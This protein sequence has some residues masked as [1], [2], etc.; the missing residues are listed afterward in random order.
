MANDLDNLEAEAA[1]VAGQISTA[2]RLRGDAE[3]ILSSE[4]VADGER[5]DAEYA[6]AENTELICQHQVTLE[7]LTEEWA[8]Q[9]AELHTWGL[10]LRELGIDPDRVPRDT[11]TA[12]AR[13]AREAWDTEPAAADQVARLTRLWRRR[14]M[15]PQLTGVGLTRR[16]VDDALAALL[17]ADGAENP[18]PSPDRPVIVYTPRAPLDTSGHLLDAPALRPVTVDAEILTDSDALTSVEDLQAA[19]R[20]VTA[21]VHSGRR[22]TSPQ[23]Q[24]QLQVILA[25]ASAAPLQIPAPMM[26]RLEVICAALRAGHRLALRT[27]PELA[28]DVWVLVS[29]DS[30]TEYRALLADDRLRGPAPTAPDVGEPVASTPAATRNPPAP[31]QV[32]VP[33]LTEDLL[34]RVCGDTDIAAAAQQAVDNQAFY[35][36]ALLDAQSMILGRLAD[37]IDPDNDA[38]TRRRARELLEDRAALTGL[39]RRAVEQVWN[40]VHDT[41]ATQAR[42]AQV[43]AHVLEFGGTEPEDLQA[44]LNALDEDLPPTERQQV[45]QQAFDAVNAVTVIDFYTFGFDAVTDEQLTPPDPDDDGRVAVAVA[46]YAEAGTAAFIRAK[47]LEGWWAG[48]SAHTAA[49]WADIRADLTAD[50]ELHTLLT[51]PDTPQTRAAAAARLDVLL[52]THARRSPLHAAAVRAAEYTQS[53]NLLGDPPPFREPAVGSGDTATGTDLHPGRDPEIAVRDALVTT[54][55]TDPGIRAGQASTASP[56][57]TRPS[58]AVP[59]AEHAEVAASATACVDCGEDTAALAEIY[60]VLPAVWAATGLGPD[61]GSLCVGCLEQRL[62][63][64]LDATDFTD[65]PTNLAHTPRSARLQQRID[66]IPVDEHT[67]YLPDPDDLDL[68]AG[69]EVDDLDFDAGDEVDGDGDLIRGDD[70]ATEADDQE[71]VAVAPRP[72]PAVIDV[73]LPEPALPVDIHA[74]TQAIPAQTPS[75]VAG[76][77]W[78]NIV[79]ELAQDPALQA[80]LRHRLLPP[81]LAVQQPELRLLL[82]RMLTDVSHLSPHHAAAVDARRDA[83]VAGLADQERRSPRPQPGDLIA[84]EVATR[85]VRALLAAEA[86]YPELTVGTFRHWATD[87]LLADPLMAACAREPASVPAAALTREMAELLIG[88]AVQMRAALGIDA[89]DPSTAEWI[90]HE[91]CLLLAPTLSSSETPW[92]YQDSAWTLDPGEGADSSDRIRVHGDRDRGWWVSPDGGLTRLS[93]G[94]DHRAAMHAGQQRADRGEGADE[95]TSAAYERVESTRR[96]LIEFADSTLSA[97]PRIRAAA[98]APQLWTGYPD[99]ALPH[100]VAEGPWTVDAVADVLTALLTD[101]PELFWRAHELGLDVHHIVHFESAVPQLRRQHSS[102]LASGEPGLQILA[103]DTVIVEDTQG[104]QLRLDNPAT[105]ADSAGAWEHRDS[106]GN[107]L[108]R[109]HRFSAAWQRARD[110]L[111]GNPIP[112]PVSGTGFGEIPTAVPETA[113]QVGTQIKRLGAWAGTQGW[114]PTSHYI[115]GE[116]SETSYTLAMHAATETVGDWE[117]LLRWQFDH[118]NGYTYQ[119]HGSTGIWRRPDGTRLEFTPQLAVLG[120]LILAHPAAVDPGPT[121][122]PQTDDDAVAVEIPRAQPDPPLAPADAEVAPS[123]EDILAEVATDPRVHAEIIN[124]QLP[125]L[126][127]AARKPLQRVVDE[128]LSE[129][130]GR[131]P[132]SEAAV[133]AARGTE[134]APHLQIRDIAEQVAQRAGQQLLAHW[135]PPLTGSELTA[136]DQWAHEQMLADPMIAARAGAA[137]RRETEIVT[138]A[139]ARNLIDRTPAQ[140][141]ELDLDVT[142]EATR[143]WLMLHVVLDLRPSLPAVETSWHFTD[144]GY[145]PDKGTGTLINRLWQVNVG[146]KALW[147]EWANHLAAQVAALEHHRRGAEATLEARRAY[148]E[149]KQLRDD[150]GGFVRGILLADPRIHAVAGAR[151]LWRYGVDG[152]ERFAL[153]RAAAKDVLAALVREEHE[154]F[155]RAHH[156]GVSVDH[157]VRREVILTLLGRLRRKPDASAPPLVTQSGLPITITGASN[158]TVADNTRDPIALVCKISPGAAPWVYQVSAEEPPLIWALDLEDAIRVADA[159]HTGRLDRAEATAIAAAARTAAARAAESRPD[160]VP[161]PDSV[162]VNW[163]A[164][165]VQPL[166]RFAADHGCTVQA[167]QWYLDPDDGSEQGYDLHLTKATTDGHHLDILLRWAPITTWAAEFDL[168]NSHIIHTYP[169]GRVE[170][171]QPQRPLVKTLIASIADTQADAAHPIATSPDTAVEPIPQASIPP[172]QAQAPAPRAPQQEPAAAPQ[173]VAAAETAGFALTAPDARRPRPDHYELDFEA[174]TDRGPVRGHLEW[175]FFGSNFRLRQSACS[176]DVNGVESTPT[177]G[178]ILNLLRRVTVIA[179]PPDSLPASAEASAGVVVVEEKLPR[180]PTVVSRLNQTAIDLDWDGEIVRDGA[181]RFELRLTPK[182]GEPLQFRMFWLMS[183]VTG[184]YNFDRWRS[185]ISH[186]GTID[187]GTIPSPKFMQDKLDQL[188]LNSTQP[189]LFAADGSIAAHLV[190]ALTEATAPSAPVE[191]TAGVEGPRPDAAPSP[192]SDSAPAPAASRAAEAVAGEPG[193]EV[194]TSHRHETVWSHIVEPLPAVIPAALAEA[195]PLADLARSNDYQV[196]SGFRLAPKDPAEV[197]DTPRDPL[198][199]LRIHGHRGISVDPLIACWRQHDGQW[200]FDEA[201]STAPRTPANLATF[202]TLV[203]KKPTATPPGAGPVLDAVVAHVLATVERPHGAHSYRACLEQLD[204]QVSTQISRVL[205]QIVDT[206]DDPDHAAQWRMAA[207]AM[208]NNPL[209]RQQ[210]TRA[211]IARI[212]IGADLTHTEQAAIRNAVDDHAYLYYQLHRSAE[213]AVRYTWEAHLGEHAKGDRRRVITAAIEVEVTDRSDEVLDCGPKVAELRAKTRGEFVDGLLTRA[214]SALQAGEGHTARRMLTAAAKTSPAVPTIADLRQIADDHFPPA[215]ERDDREIPVPDNAA[216]IVS[217]T[218]ADDGWTQIRAREEGH[219]FV[220]TLRRQSR[221]GRRYHLRLVWTDSDDGPQ[222]DPDASRASVI[223]DRKAEPFPKR[224]TRHYAARI[225]ALAGDQTMPPLPSQH[226]IAPELTIEQRILLYGLDPWAVSE[227]LADPHHGVP[228]LFDRDETAVLNSQAC[229]LHPDLRDTAPIYEIADDT[230]A[231]AWPGGPSRTVTLTRATLTELAGAVSDT[232]R[233]RLANHSSHSARHRVLRELLDLDTLTSQASGTEPGEDPVAA[234][235][236]PTLRSDP[237]GEVA[238]AYLP[239]LEG[240]H[241]R[242][243]AASGRLDLYAVFTHAF[244]D[245]L[246]PSFLRVLAQSSEFDTAAQGL[247]DS[248]VEGSADEATVDAF[249]ARVAELGWRRWRPGISNDD[250]RA[251]GELDERGWPRPYRLEPGRERVSSVLFDRRSSSPIEINLHVNDADYRV[252]GHPGGG[253]QILAPAGSTRPPRVIATL[254]SEQANQILGIIRADVAPEISTETGHLDE[255]GMAATRSA[256]PEGSG[257]DVVA[258]EQRWPIPKLVRLSK[259]KLTNGLLEAVRVVTDEP[260]KEALIE[261]ASVLSNTS[262]ARKNGG[263]EAVARRDAE[264]GPEQ[265]YYAAMADLADELDRRGYGAITIAMHQ[266]STRPISVYLR[267][268]AAAYMQ[269]RAELENTSATASPAQALPAPPIAGPAPRTVLGTAP[270]TAATD[271]DVQAIRDAVVGWVQPQLENQYSDLLYFS[272]NYEPDVDRGATLKSRPFAAGLVAGIVDTLPTANPE[273]ASAVAA[274]GLDA[275]E[276][277]TDLVGA[278]LLEL[279]T[280]YNDGEQLV[281]NSLFV[282][283]PATGRV[284]LVYEPGPHPVFSEYGQPDSPI[285]S[286]SLT[287]AIG[288]ARAF[289]AHRDTSIPAQR[290]RIPQLPATGQDRVADREAFAQALLAAALSGTTGYDRWACVV[291]AEMLQNPQWADSSS[292]VVARGLDLAYRTPADLAARWWP[293]LAQSHFTAVRELADELDRLGYHDFGVAGGGDSIPETLG[294]ALRQYAELCIDV[295]TDLATS[296]D[297]DTA[298]DVPGPAVPAVDADRGNESAQ[299]APTVDERGASATGTASADAD[300]WRIPAH[301]AGATGKVKKSLSQ[302]LRRAANR[303][304]TSADDGAALIMAADSLIDTGWARGGGVRAQARELADLD[305]S[306]YGHTRQGI[307]ARVTAI[308]DLGEELRRLG[309]TDI[310]IAKIPGEQPP[311]LVEYLREYASEYRARRAEQDQTRSRTITPVSEVASAAAEITAA[312]TT[313]EPASEVVPAADDVS[314][315]PGLPEPGP[316]TVPEKLDG[317]DYLPTA[318]QQAVYDA[319]EAGKN[320]KVQAGAGAGKT[321]TLIGLSRRLARKDPAIRIAY[322]A[323][324]KSVQEHAEKEFP[325]GTV[326]PRTGHSIAYRWAPQWAKQRSKPWDQEQEK[327]TGRLKPLRRPDEVAAH[328]GI[329]EPLAIG[330]QPPLSITEQAMAAVRAVDTYAN[331]ADDALERKHLPPRLHRLPRPSQ[332]A[333]VELAN[334]AWTDLNDPNGRL[335]LKLDHIRKMWALTSP[336]FTRPGSGLRRAADVVFLDEAQDTP[337]VLARVM[338]ENQQRMQVVLVGDQDQA[339]YGFTGAVDYLETATADADLPLTTSWRFGPQ[340]ADIGNRFLQLL[341][342]RKRIEGGGPDSQ[343][344]PTGTMSAPDAILVRSNGGAI[345]EIAREIGAGRTVGVPKGTKADLESLVDSARYLR[346]EGQP[347]YRM[348]E[349]LDPFRTWAEVVDEADKG[350]NPKLAMLVRIVTKHGLP[351]L[352]RLVQQVHELGETPFEGVE[353]TDLPVG[354]VADRK[355]SYDI[356]NALKDAGFVYRE[357]PGGG[358]ISRGP[359]RGQPRRAWVAEGTPAERQAKLDR[360]K[361]IAAAATVDVIVSTAHKA[362]GL[363][364]G[365]VRISDDFKGPTIDADTGEWVWPDP[366][367]LRLAYVA[368]TRAR[369]E[370]DPGSLAYVFDHTD[371][372]GIAPALAPSSLAV[373]TEVSAEPVEPR[374]V[375]DAV[376]DAAPVAAEPSRSAEPD[377]VALPAG[378]VLPD[379]AQELASGAAVKGW[380]VE[381]PTVTVDDGGTVVCGLRVSA[382][383]DRGLRDYHLFWRLD[384]K[385]WRFDQTASRADHVAEAKRKPVRPSQVTNDINNRTVSDTTT[386][387]APDVA[388]SAKSSRKS[389]QRQAK[390]SRTASDIAAP[391]TVEEVTAQ[392]RRLSPGLFA[393]LAVAVTSSDKALMENIQATPGGFSQPVRGVYFQHKTMKFTL[394]EPGSEEGPRSVEIAWKD[395]SEHWIQPGMSPRRRDVLHQISNL[396][397]RYL[398]YDAEWLF[399]LIDQESLYDEVAAELAHIGELARDDVLNVAEQLRHRADQPLAPT[400]SGS[401]VPVSDRQ[402]PQTDPPATEAQLEAL[403]PRLSRWEPF[404]PANQHWQTPFNVEDLKVGDVIGKLTFD[405]ILVLHDLPRRTEAGFEATGLRIHRPEGRNSPVVRELDTITFSVFTGLNLITMPNLPVPTT[406]TVPPDTTAELST[407]ATADAEVVAEAGD[408]SAAGPQAKAFTEQEEVITPQGAGYI[409]SISP[410]GILVKENSGYT[411]YS[412]DQLTRPGET[413]DDPEPQGPDPDDA[414]LAQAQS[415]AGLPLRSG[416]ARLVD[417]NVAEGHGTVVGDDGEVLG[418]IRRRDDTWFGQDARGGRPHISTHTETTMSGTAR[419]AELAAR[420]VADGARRDTVIHVGPPW[421]IVEPDAVE[422]AVMYSELTKTQ[423]G[424]LR[425][426]TK[427][428]ADSADTALRAAARRWQMGISVPQMRLLAS[429]IDRVAGSVDLST[430][431]GRTRQEVLRRLATRIR[432]QA[433]TVAGARSTLPRP[434]EPDPWAGPAPVATPRDAMATATRRDLDGC[435]SAG[436]VPNDQP[437]VEDTTFSAVLAGQPR[438]PAHTHATAGVAVVADIVARTAANDAAAGY[439]G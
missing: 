249:T 149:V 298:R 271:T 266:G 327:T 20:A 168:L 35:P 178:E 292:N 8:A 432:E 140:F 55:L 103:R 421:G 64:H 9:H 61:D 52:D 408:A 342:S 304:G 413:R 21:Q 228:N 100:A 101:A 170:R 390:S 182:R 46:I 69:D 125:P 223:S 394:G 339:I 30:E 48:L 130:A 121:S 335:R 359:K 59:V 407:S 53:A 425:A 152:A 7:R 137:P 399:A 108:I 238:E 1:T 341:G 420:H 437:L 86:S 81:A 67:E 76:V 280:V 133:L 367:E 382:D 352:D 180:L 4:L 365:R 218:S 278:P 384:G 141:P 2:N 348:H 92:Q 284:A 273:L 316:S 354:L 329:V 189:A 241:L 171:Y 250:E 200:L 39:A 277:A 102:D 144:Y 430:R 262:W 270:D 181:E 418:W 216:T 371:P 346:G 229:A 294:A 253:I 411:L 36:Q 387:P 63:R 347:P 288:A 12:M 164:D 160:D 370:L 109:E 203:A 429:E 77:T 325:A 272:A 85:A 242:R 3:Q 360:A 173:I 18:A 402:A 438:P 127:V 74:T 40:T 307:D 405:D 186:D 95:E 154:L 177:V 148:T 224:L 353:F 419:S 145:H 299:P 221:E 57:Q 27:D 415:S 72:A 257:S 378:V 41:T 276:I 235:A 377:L 134:Q 374:P 25:S 150:L 267:Q 254:H 355:T 427:Q 282:G 269:R 275:H 300:R 245:N 246:N 397:D 128:Q 314:A 70:E 169:D 195:H 239:T 227:A 423:A 79:G 119:P 147:K 183:P 84:E 305:V 32:Q 122:D 233:E 6:A 385:T 47:Y 225:I 135:P 17:A 234:V 90:R 93:Y 206:V 389:G 165:S 209:I 91:V 409:V 322:I 78:D 375:L 248:L 433:H 131:S 139:V 286:A 22:A 320:I 28:L 301:A 45:A 202:T 434:G 364:W 401:E 219:P 217:G 117:L 258:G 317:E 368:V 363:E 287:E 174:N 243:L 416:H 426:L 264:D 167:R 115:P 349:D 236:L 251:T 296:E 380:T 265:P 62:E 87:H 220:V 99:G 194:Q 151:P 54:L 412:E 232:D 205:P 175:G 34:Q 193:I 58:D 343:I 142:D 312:D 80:G 439:G 96:E 215:P 112:A 366:E 435:D 369:G 358:V 351:E 161:A 281:G 332:D 310:T 13:P 331:S 324:N 38:A 328:L 230:I 295:H 357:I 345:A 289:I 162:P 259:G 66:T 187:A 198:F 157:F 88:R 111:G 60:D 406:I 75:P 197:V 356:K 51:A 222:F 71:V 24:R 163:H 37:L 83:L 110:L 159:L 143:Q 361:E 98:R 333:L 290:W 237:I 326:E 436:A 201:A 338:S 196:T 155:V 188:Y 43:T 89:T 373:H 14:G 323:F 422:A 398:Q 132:A 252:C 386:S 116:H 362:K 213:D 311:T 255:P 50:S 207:V 417:L 350:D 129:I 113:A 309:Y 337:D 146:K 15:P 315:D 126:L 344:V 185:G 404:L 31:Q 392:L 240:S 16:G 192:V 403:L 33:D 256:V 340:V 65:D 319:A 291:A 29:D 231:V 114:D 285:R 214:L 44:G 118:R 318:Q 73:L 11:V 308:A 120:A 210:L 393:K 431:Q 105:S 313:A 410:D 283:D 293:T 336:D 136:W 330:D 376:I 49:V 302:T 5:A 244:I 106:G 176:L 379:K 97:D 395:L 383:T 166:A 123:W 414:K 260:D 372:N 156:I 212:Y 400:L 204:A 381:G 94:F 191:D 19:L 261:A 306:M 82:A 334:T 104:R 274:A 268:R 42:A 124:S 279:F 303:T 184:C 138:R 26:G 153:T 424:E 263:F 391:L 10:L 56:A 208:R 107:L 179:A 226:N 247:V 321:S 199:E 297:G 211:I 158:V 396:S 23:V 190:D 428:W 68:Y 172:P 388:L